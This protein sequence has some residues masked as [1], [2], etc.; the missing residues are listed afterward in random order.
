MVDDGAFPHAV[1]AAEDV[2]VG[3]QLPNDVLAPLPQGF[4]FDALN[5]VSSFL[6]VPFAVFGIC[7]FSGA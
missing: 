1:D 7:V 3:L 5:V 2:Y 6:H 4:D